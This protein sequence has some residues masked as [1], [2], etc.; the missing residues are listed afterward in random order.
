MSSS[1][2]GVRWSA[3]LAASCTS[4]SGT[5]SSRAA[6]NRGDEGVAQ[7]VRPDPLEDACSA[8]DATHDPTGGVRARRSVFTTRGVRR[9]AAFTE[10]A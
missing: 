2:A 9:L 4:R 5:P 1:P 6:E 10:I 3:W 7:S 8:G